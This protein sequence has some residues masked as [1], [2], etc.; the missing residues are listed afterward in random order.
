MPALLCYPHSIEFLTMNNAVFLNSSTPDPLL[1]AVPG[2]VNAR[3]GLVD[4]QPMFQLSWNVPQ[5]SGD[6]QRKACHTR[7]L[8]LCLLIVCLANAAFNGLPFRRLA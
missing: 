2:Q 1:V 5:L 7:L 3:L 4:Y 6:L 8:L